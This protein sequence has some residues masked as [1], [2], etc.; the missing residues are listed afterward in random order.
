MIFFNREKELLVLKSIQES[1]LKTGQFTAVTGRRRIGK[2]QLLLKAFENENYLYFFVSKKSEPLLCRDFQIEIEK[3]LGLP[4]LGEV[5]SVISILEYLIQYAKR[6]S[7]TLIIDEFQEFM[8]INPSIFSDLQK[9]WDLNHKQS[10]INLIVSGSVIS[11]MYQIFQNHKEPLFG[12]ANHNLHIKPFETSVLKEILSYYNP[13][14]TPD[15]LLALYSFSG[16][17]AK[18][19]QILMDSK[20]FKKEAMIRHILSE[21]SILIQEAKNILIEEF[22]KEYGTYFSV[23]SEL[24]QGRNRRSEIESSLQK[25][26]GGYLTKLE[27]DFNLIKRSTPVLSNKN[28]NKN[29]KYILEDNFFI[30]WFRFIFKYLHMIEIGAFEQLQRIVLRDYETYSGL[31]LEKYFRT[32]AIESKLYTKVGNYWNRTGTLEIDYIAMNEI[33]KKIVIADIKRN[34][35]RIKI[36]NLQVQSI[37]LLQEYREF[38][39]YQMEVIGLS[40]DEM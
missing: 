16:G 4:I 19:V 32:K 24:A 3:K 12:R 14:Y 2:T 27:K 20:A 37:Q 11:M 34:P 39:D 15:D 22:G 35:K 17:V 33:D 26:V 30:F 21:N 29:L 31:L 6:H 18:Y 9:V 8:N 28:E 23:L 13:K 5:T 25:E 38:T 7:I 36:N 40:L 10:K 1:S